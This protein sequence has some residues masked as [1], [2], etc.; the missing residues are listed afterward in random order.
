MYLL[1]FALFILISPGIFTKYKTSLTAITLHAL[2]FVCI[3]FTIRKYY[4]SYM[5]EGFA[6]PNENDLVDLTNIKVQINRDPAYALHIYCNELL[7]TNKIK[8]SDQQ[9]ID[10]PANH[11][12]FCQNVK[13]KNT[14]AVNA[15]LAKPA[16]DPTRAFNSEALL[17]STCKLGLP[18]TTIQSDKINIT[19]QNVQR[20]KAVTYTGSTISSM[21]YQ[22]IIH[23]K[24]I[25]TQPLTTEVLLTDIIG[26]YC[27]YGYVSYSPNIDNIC[28]KYVTPQRP[29]K[30]TLKEYVSLITSMFPPW[31]KCKEK[32]NMKYVPDSSNPN[33][34]AIIAYETAL[35]TTT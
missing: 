31:T 17:S 23:F 16:T 35:N 22:P 25:E 21:A 4:A 27:N 19:A 18:F 6:T 20:L 29:S 15:E 12:Q 7:T 13:A 2:I 10:A 30:I 14:T 34:A 26:F 9:T 5:L 32:F 33:L 28:L 3:I 11:V 8:V 24:N 1:L